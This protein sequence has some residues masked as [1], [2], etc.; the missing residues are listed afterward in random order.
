MNSN[1]RLATPADIDRLTDFIN[2]TCGDPKEWL[3]GRLEYMIK[4]H[5]VVL[6]ETS[7][8]EITGRMFFYAKENPLL[9]VGE[10]EGMQVADEFQGKGIGSGIIKLGIQEAQHYFERFQVKL[11]CLYLMTRSDNAPAIGLYEKFG[12]KKQGEIGKIFKQD[13]PNEEIMALFF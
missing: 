8:T 1:I 3:R 12:F 13:E 2:Q 7:T 4:D 5:F 11:H 9:G 6:A 10:F